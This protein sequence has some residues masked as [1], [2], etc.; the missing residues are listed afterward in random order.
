[1]SKASS[2]ED[3][4][5]KKRIIEAA[6]S[7]FSQKGYLATSIEDIISVSGSS[8]GNLYHHFSNKE[9]LV[10]YLIRKQIEQWLEEWNAKRNDYTTFKDLLYGLADH[11]ALDLQ[12]PLARAAVEFSSSE[13]ANP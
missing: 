1:M 11:V 13:T 5:G 3:T 8:K 4:P 10:L 2:T 12:N 9:G 7:F 6:Q